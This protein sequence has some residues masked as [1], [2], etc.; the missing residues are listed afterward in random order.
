MQHGIPNKSAGL[1]AVSGH[2][3]A[4]TRQWW[5]ERAAGGA[6]ARGS[7]GKSHTYGCKLQTA[8]AVPR[9]RRNTCGQAC[10]ASKLSS[11]VLR[12]VSSGSFEYFEQNYKHLLGGGST[13]I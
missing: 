9:H 11:P 2:A 6:V 4:S 12:S 13:K 1:R 7:R 5:L 8:T 10:F 3:A